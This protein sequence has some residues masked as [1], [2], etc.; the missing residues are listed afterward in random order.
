MLALRDE[1]L[2]QTSLLGVGGFW[3]GDRWKTADTCRTHPLVE[4]GTNDLSSA[5][6]R[7]HTDSQ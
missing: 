7:D 5:L 2:S 4:E 3:P 6:S 1:G